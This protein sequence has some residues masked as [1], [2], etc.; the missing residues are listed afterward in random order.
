MLTP[1]RFQPGRLRLL[2]RPT[3]T[4][5]LLLANA[6]GMVAVAALAARAAALPKAAMTATLRRTRSAASAGSRSNCSS[7]QRKSNQ[8]AVRDVAALGEAF[9][10]RGDRARALLV[11]E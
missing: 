1:V 2:T 11:L 7:A 4:G 10:E 8:V 6:M 3:A 5:S 9:L